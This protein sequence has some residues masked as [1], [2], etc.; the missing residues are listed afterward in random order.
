MLQLHVDNITTEYER[1]VLVVKSRYNT[2]Q[3]KM[4]LWTVR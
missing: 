1:A 3:Y 4:I 2:V